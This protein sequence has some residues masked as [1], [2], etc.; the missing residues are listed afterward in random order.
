VAASVHQLSAPAASPARRL[1]TVLIGLAA[2]ALSIFGGCAT[3]PKHYTAPDSGPLTASQAGYTAAVDRAHASAREAAASI[4]AA[5]ETAARIVPLIGDAKG[6]LLTLFRLAP[7]DLQPLVRE[8]QTDVADI[9][10][11]HA[12]TVLQLERA[13]M[14]NAEL[15]THLAE[16]D[17]EKPELGRLSADYFAKV[18][19][20]AAEATAERGKRIEAEKSLSGYRWRWWA[21]WMVAGAGVVFAVIVWVLAL[22]HRSI[23]AASPV[24]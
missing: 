2:L 22:R 1:L 17:A 21:S 4:H 16:A 6:K 15:E 12:E 23:P 8:V 3:R 14:R 19:A 9:Q 11:G 10:A 20:L 5:R 13:E 24:R 18:D 7:P